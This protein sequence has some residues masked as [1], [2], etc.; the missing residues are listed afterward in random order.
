[1]LNKSEFKKMSKV[2]NLIANYEDQLAIGKYILAMTKRKVYFDDCDMVDAIT[3]ATIMHN[4]LTG[5][6]T[7]GDLVSVVKSM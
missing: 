2:A 6:H 4:A 1:M 7:I 3:S 5:T